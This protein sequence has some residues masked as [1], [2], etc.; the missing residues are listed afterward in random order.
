MAVQTDPYTFTNGTV[1]NATEVNLRFT[2]LYNLQNGAIDAA[3]MDLTDDFAWTGLHEFQGGVAFERSAYAASN[4]T[5]ATDVIAGVTDTSAARTI[6]IASA[7]IAAA[8][9]RYIIVK[10]EYGRA[11]TF[12]VTVACEGAETIDGQATVDI[13][14]DYGFLVMYSDGTNLFVVGC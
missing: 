7:L 10:D 11:G 13:V 12:N 1:A 5:A 6:T 8:A 2:R 14:E 9:G 4:T 3:N